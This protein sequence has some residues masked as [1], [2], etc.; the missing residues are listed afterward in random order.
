MTDI[1]KLNLKAPKLYKALE[2]LSP[3]SL[4]ATQDEYVTSFEDLV[5]E[6][7]VIKQCKKELKAA[8]KV[9]NKLTKLLPKLEKKI[10]KEMNKA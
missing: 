9:A 10:L 1:P 6:L 3:F 8:E 7:S 5:R 4:T 2:N